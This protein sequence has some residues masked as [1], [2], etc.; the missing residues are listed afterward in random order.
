MSI[1]TKIK[2]KYA[3]YRLAKVNNLEN[4]VKEIDGC[5]TASASSPEKLMPDKLKITLKTLPR[6]LSIAKNM[7]M[8]VKSLKNNPYNPKVEAEADFIKQF[9]DYAGSIG[10]DSI[11]YTNVPSTL[12]FKDKSILFDNAIILIM[13]MDKKAVDTAPSPETQEMSNVTYDE[14]GKRTNEL[15]GFLRENGFAAHASHPAGGVV[16]YPHLAQK[17]GLGYRGTHGMIITPKFGPRQRLSAIFTS[18][19]NLPVNTDDDHSWIPEFCAK[20]GK[21]IK[22]CPGN[23]IIQEKSSETGITRTKVINDLCS[24]CTICMRGCS[25]NRRGYMQIKDTY[26]KSKEIIS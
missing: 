14:L 5:V 8:T 19:Q 17:A 20:C 26:E 11:C 18:I 21:C 2:D 1:V 13:E 9:E 12:I 23:A 16:M 10:V 6:Q 25:F 3:G 22:N 7:E 24:G 15:A 4:S